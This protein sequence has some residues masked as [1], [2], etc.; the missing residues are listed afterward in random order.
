[1]LLEYTT[2]GYS[3]SAGVNHKLGMF[4]WTGSAAASRATYDQGGGGLST[5]ENYSSNFS[6]K[7][8]SVGGAYSKS[9][10]NSILTSTGLV[11]TPLPPGVLP[12][13]TILFDGTSYSASGS[14]IP[15][16]G[17]Q[18]TGSW[19]TA[20]SSDSLLSSSTTSSSE[21]SSQ[22]NFRL[23]YIFRKLTFDAGYTKFHQSFS[24]ST[25]GAANF[26]TYYFGIQRWFNIL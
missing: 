22:L 16:R 7:Y 25:T 17:L 4:Q 20:R 23:T 1:L 11:S 12:F 13:A 3:Y 24:T 14:V 10:G 26:S 15:H 9:R 21:S 2:S 8:G 18:L 19:V 5:S 6:A